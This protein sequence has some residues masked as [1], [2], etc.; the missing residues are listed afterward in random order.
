VFITLTSH[1]SAARRRLVQGRQVVHAGR[2]V[3]RSLQGTDLMKLH[4]G[5]KFLNI[6]NIKYC[7]NFHPGAGLVR[8]T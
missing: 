5:R 7:E 2:R 8:Q 1:H 3:R 4:F 6:L